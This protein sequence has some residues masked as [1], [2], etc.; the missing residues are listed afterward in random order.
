MVLKSV[1]RVLRDFRVNSR[2]SMDAGNPKEVSGGLESVSWVL[3]G[4]RRPQEVP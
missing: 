2:G 3:G 4:F 1:S